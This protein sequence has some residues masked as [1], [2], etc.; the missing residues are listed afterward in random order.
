M[1]NPIPRL[2]IHDN[3]EH[4]KLFLVTNYLNKG[5]CQWNE[6][7]DI[8]SLACILIELYTGELF[9]P[10]HNN[11]EHLCLIE[12]A[13]GKKCSYLGY[14]PAWMA[15]DSKKEFRKVF[16]FVECK[17]THVLEFKIRNV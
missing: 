7:S 17:N 6:K 9:F 12:R 5:C 8:W 3:I 11:F 1:M 13:I 16:D 2:S 4:L 10:T 15:E 14:I